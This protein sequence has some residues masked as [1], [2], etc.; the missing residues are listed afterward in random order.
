MKKP[1]TVIN[2]EGIT[3][4]RL[5]LRELPIIGQCEQKNTLPFLANKMKFLIF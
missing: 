1:H 5:V 2:I 4:S 3:K